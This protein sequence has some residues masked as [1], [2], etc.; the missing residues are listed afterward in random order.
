MARQAV[1]SSLHPM[2][3]DEVQFIRENIDIFC[4]PKCAGPLDVDERGIGCAQC[5]LFRDQSDNIP[6]LF[7]PNEWDPSAPDVTDRIKSFYE[8][9]PFPNYDGFDNVASLLDKSRRSVF[10]KLLDDQVPLGSRIIE[11][12]CGT[13]QMSNFLSIG[14]R[15]VVGTDLCLN[16]LRLAQSFKEKNNLSR[17]LFV[18]MNLFRPCFRPESF[19]LVIS[20][21]VL[22]H[23]SDPLLGFKTI[24]AL[25]KPGRF[26]LIGLYHRYGRITN[27]LRVGLF[28]LT[29][30]RFKSIDKRLVDKSISAEKKNAW[31]RDQY[32]NPHES[33]HTIGQVFHWVKEVG[34]ELVSTIPK[35]H[36]TFDTSTKLFS[37][38]PP[39]SRFS[40][41]VTDFGMLF[42]GRS[43]GG[44][45]IVIAKKPRNPASGPT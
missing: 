29:R 45:F 21:G 8:D 43:E 19:D 30:D 37:P 41:F 28:K 9:T 1:N 13:G 34:L 44:F 10:A 35:V 25:A 38:D 31:F 40:R 6:Q 22:H 2:R 7:Y 39:S 12:G 33:K 42:G 32:K 5:R 14:N 18:Q 3:A 15:T 17:V 16:S 24:A 27:D 26:V 4:C 36:G 11:C 23:T 20:N